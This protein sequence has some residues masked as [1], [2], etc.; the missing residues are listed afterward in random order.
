MNIFQLKSMQIWNIRLNEYLRYWLLK[1]LKSVSVILYK[2]LM[3]KKSERRVNI[4]LLML[5]K[6]EDY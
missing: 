4:H 1:A 2:L 3:K 6:C 5:N